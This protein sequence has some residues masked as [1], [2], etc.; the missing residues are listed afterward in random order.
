MTGSTAF[1]AIGQR[2]IWCSI[3]PNSGRNLYIVLQKLR[4]LRL[5]FLEHL[6]KI[7][8]LLFYQKCMP[9]GSTGLVVFFR[10]VLCVRQ[11]QVWNPQYKCWYAP[12][13]CFVPDS[14]FIFPNYLLS[15]AIN[16]FAD[17]NTLSFSY[18]FP[19]SL[20]CSS[21]VERQRQNMISSLNSDLNSTVIY[22]EFRAAWNWMLRKLKAAWC[23]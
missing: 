6:I 21:D 12:G 3:S 7:G 4:L 18:L 13:L 23:R 16:Y 19:D 17:N 22:G 20:S 5:I 15:A 2:V 8:I 14:I 10:T 9:S 11:V 1:A